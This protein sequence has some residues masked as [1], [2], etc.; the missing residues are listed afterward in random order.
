MKF[1]VIGGLSFVLCMITA[2]FPGYATEQAPDRL[3][4]GGDT[5]LL[6]ALPLEQWKERNQWDKPFFPDSLLEINTGCWRGY[7]AYWEVIDN[8]LYLTD[9]YNCDR[10]AKTELDVLFPGKVQDN[11]VYADWFSDT[12]TTYNGELIYYEHSGFSAIYEHEWELVFAEGH[13]ISEKY[14]DNSL[15]KNTPVIM[16]DGHDLIPMID[17]LIN[18]STLPPIEKELKVVLWVET[19][20]QGRL[21]SIHFERSESEP[22]NREAVRVLGL[23]THRLPIIYKR[24]RFL[25]KIFA[26]PFVFTP[27]KQ[28]RFRSVANITSADYLAV[29]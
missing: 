3:V 27:E 16:W 4:I 9:I 10:S 7:I 22:F 18:W 14:F 25:P 17:S 11:R 26:V 21:D 29:K 19:D 12:V 2:S 24:G 20:E 13:K 1:T 6:H 15:S 28:R 23:V 5:L 8:R